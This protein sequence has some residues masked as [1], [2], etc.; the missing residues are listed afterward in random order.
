MVSNRP[1]FGSALGHVRLGENPQKEIVR[2][3]VA[4]V[5]GVVPPLVARELP[6]VP[7]GKLILG[8]SVGRQKAG[9][10]IAGDGNGHQQGVFPVGIVQAASFWHFL[11]P[12]VLPGQ[13]VK[14]GPYGL[15]EGTGLVL[16]PGKVVA[17]GH[18]VSERIAVFGGILPDDTAVGGI[19][20]DV[21]P[22]PH[23]GK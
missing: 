14:V 5:G 15:D 18:H 20:R 13:I 11:R 7:S 1:L 12:A 4:A 21:F 10:G 22:I 19:R 3:L 2:V 8:A 6:L 9:Q 16:R 23:A 17:V